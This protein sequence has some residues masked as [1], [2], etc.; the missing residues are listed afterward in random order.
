M[1]RAKTHKKGAPKK[2]KLHVVEATTAGRW[3]A[4]LPS[5][6]PDIFQFAIEEN[7]VRTVLELP[8]EWRRDIAVHLLGLDGARVSVDLS[9]PQPKAP[10]VECP[11]CSV[12]PGEKCRRQDGKSS[13]SYHKERR[14]AAKAAARDQQGGRL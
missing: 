2:P 12:K 11:K 14:A 8:R 13:K 3:G 4:I 7:G 9:W 10:D 6:H 1:P 5:A